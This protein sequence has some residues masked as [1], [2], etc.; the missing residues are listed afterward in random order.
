MWYASIVKRSAIS[1][2]RTRCLS[3]CWT[4]RKNGIGF[5][6]M[7]L[8]GKYS[9]EAT[10]ARM[11]ALGKRTCTDDGPRISSSSVLSVKLIYGLAE[12]TIVVRS[13]A[14]EKYL[15]QPCDESF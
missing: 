7:Q 8:G 5:K 11:L 10:K 12:R 1:D 3:I 14:N 9:S 13:E 2:R 6:G 4:T 15:H